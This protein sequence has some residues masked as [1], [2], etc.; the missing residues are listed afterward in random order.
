MKLHSVGAK[1]DRD[2]A[3]LLISYREMCRI[4]RVK[5]SERVAP[6]KLAA[7]PTPQV[8]QLCKDL[9][10]TLPVKSAHKLE[11]RLMPKPTKARR[12]G[13]FSLKYRVQA[14]SARVW[15]WFFHLKRKFSKP[16]AVHG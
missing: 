1:A 7:M 16:E 12:F 15:L 9:Y 13:Q 11:A 6:E 8:F 2:R 14:V 4:L 3:A 10:N 5:R